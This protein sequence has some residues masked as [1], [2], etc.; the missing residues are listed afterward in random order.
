MDQFL[1]VG[2]PMPFGMLL[3]RLIAL[4]FAFEA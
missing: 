2:I 4:V 1:A 3:A